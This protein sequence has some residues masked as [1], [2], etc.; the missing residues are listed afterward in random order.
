MADGGR[1]SGAK[2]KALKITGLLPEEAGNYT[3]QVTM[4]AQ[5]NAVVGTNG[6]T[7]VIV[8]QRPTV[9]PFVLENAYVGEDINFVIPRTN[10]PTSFTVSGLPSGVVVSKTGVLSGKPKSAKLVVGVPSAYVLKVSASNTAGAS[11]ARLVNWTILPL[12]SGAI[13]T[14]NGLVERHATLNGG[15]GGSI[16][17]V[18][19]SSGGFTGTLK[20]GALSYPL[21]GALT[22]PPGGGNPTG[23]VAL[24][25]KV[26]LTNLTVTWTIHLDTGE[27]EGEIDDPIADPAPLRAWRTPWSSTNKATLYAYNYTAALTPEVAAP[28][29]TT[30]APLW[31]EGEGYALL[32]ISNTGIATWSGKLAD[33]TA[34]TGSTTAGP[35][36]EV[37]LQMMLYTNTGS[38]RGWAMI[39][40]TGNLDNDG[41]IDWAKAAQPAKSTTR[42]YKGGIP[43]HELTLIGGRYLK[44]S[45]GPLL[46]LPN[47]PA[48]AQV[49][50][51]GGGLETDLA[52]A[53]TITDKNAVQVPSSTQ[54]PNTVKVTLAAGTGLI[55]G[56]FLPGP[57]VP[58]RTASFN[59]ILVPRLGRGAGHFLL[60]RLPEALGETMS[61]TSILSGGMALG[62]AAATP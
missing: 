35:H 37:A 30:A 32:A 18:T 49:Q 34:I 17:V 47:A 11:A 15:L 3:C 26:P 52:Q 58:K 1:V 22:T 54:N 51:I 14:F 6:D 60:Q 25:R 28:S 55:S 42:S 13:G 56:T 4:T 36:G 53:F 2:T 43:L 24:V 61:N 62:A 59:G 39:D 27:M 7:P 41:I 38:L 5:G 45:S 33:G 12:A 50:F 21:V 57:A 31:P 10:N 9:E 44:P 16:K 23:R 19:I 8:V 29:E 46:G 48:N 40:A 20:L